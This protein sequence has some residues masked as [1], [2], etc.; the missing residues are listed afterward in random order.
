MRALHRRDD[1]TRHT[2]T[3]RRDAAARHSRAHA[4]HE[5]SVV[6]RADEELRQHV[7]K[8]LGEAAVLEARA[9][10]APRHRAVEDDGEQLD[11]LRQNDREVDV[12]D[13]RA[14][15]ATRQPAWVR[16]RVRRQEGAAGSSA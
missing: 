16:R 3:P 4:H 13:L 10:A 5:Q 6:E 1:A 8:E 12:V 11:E 15:A 7:L 9:L 2:A 14:E